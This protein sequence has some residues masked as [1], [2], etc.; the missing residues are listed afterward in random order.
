[1]DTRKLLQDIWEIRTD[2][3]DEIIRKDSKYNDILEEQE[4]K[5]KEVEA[6]NLSK[7]DLMLYH[8]S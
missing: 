7:E 1:M 2:F 6:L 5:W 4:E 3:L 8:F